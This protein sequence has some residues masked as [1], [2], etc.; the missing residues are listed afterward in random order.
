MT[1]FAYTEY[2]AFDP[3]ETKEVEPIQ[4]TNSFWPTTQLFSMN[5]AAILWDTPP[6]PTPSVSENKEQVCLYV[7]AY[8][9]IIM[10]IC[11]YICVHHTQV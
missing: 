5:P 2:E 9:C 7:W 10:K 11:V 6:E 4:E 8:V 3:L 1:I